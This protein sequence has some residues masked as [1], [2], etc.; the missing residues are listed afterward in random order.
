MENVYFYSAVVAGTL[1]AGQFLLSLMGFGDD[2]DLDDVGGGDIDVDGDVDL[3]GD[4][5]GVDHGGEWFVGILS[6]RAIVAAVT[7][8]GLSGLAANAS[9]QFDGLTTFA[10]ALVAG[11]VMLYAVGSMLKVLYQMKA[12][13][14]VRIGRTVGESGTVYLTIPAAKSGV[15]KVTVEVQERVM[16]F[17]AVTA[18]KELP[19]GAPVVIV[20]VVSPGTVEVTEAA[21]P[22]NE[23]KSHV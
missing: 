17:E 3:D 5:D 9:G 20:N 4:A 7:V 8:F 10:I 23:G 22:I 12:D 15:G 19:S 18:G 16:E 6:F 14:T 11:G 2:V 21:E 13:G 1:M